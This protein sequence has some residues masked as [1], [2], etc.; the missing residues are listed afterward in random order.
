M[1]Y[2]DVHCHLQDARLS[3]N[4]IEIVEQL[5]QAGV[6]K[7]VVN[8]TNE[9]DWDRVS[10]LADRYDVVIP[11]YGLHPWF[12]KDRSP[13]WEETLHSRL[14]DPRA[15]VGEIGLDRWIRDHDIEDQI[16]VFET[17]LSIAARINRPVSIHCLKAWGP[18]LE[19]LE[20]YR[21]RID[22]MLLHSFGGS[23][24]VARQL[25]SLGACFS[26]SGYFFH[27]RKAKQLELFKNLPMNRLLLETDAPDMLGPKC[28]IYREFE[29]ES[30]KKLNHPVNIVAIYRAWASE[31]G[32]DLEELRMKMNANFEAFLGKQLRLGN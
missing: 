30:S 19:S 17:Q 8:G 21:G 20:R 10:E 29:D 9:C 2:Y 24:E 7:I 32:V 3:G 1:S 27:E 15:L 16:D 23:M 5:F 12:A 4:L 31:L 14:T 18:L 25:L 11:S 6:R 13:N 28:S 22:R 26:L